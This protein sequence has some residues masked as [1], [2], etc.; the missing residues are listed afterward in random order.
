MKY[1]Q[2][3][4][5]GLLLISCGKDKPNEFS[6][7]VKVNGNYKEYLYLNYDNKKDSSL[8][9]NGR[10]FFNGSVSYPISA[11][12]GTNYISAN[13]KIFYL[14]NE[15][16]ETEITI[17][18]KKIKEY[19][20]DWITI[21]KISGT[22]ASIIGKDFE[23]FKQNSKPDKNWQT[24]LFE[25]LKTI[26]SQNPKH[27]YAG[28]LLSDISNDTILSKEQIG[29]LYNKLDIQFQ[30]PYSVK[31]IKSKAFPEYKIKVNDSIYDFALPN[32]EKILISTKD[33]RGQ[34]LFIDFWASWCKPC[35]AQF[36]ELTIINNDFKE[37]GVKILGVSIDEKENDWLKTM[38][39]EK[40]KWKNVIDIEGFS[41]KLADKYGIFA[42]PYNVL[43]DEKG[44][45]IAND[46]SLGKL[47][48]VLDSITSVRKTI[49]NK[50]YTKR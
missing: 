2:I 40:P 45:V 1:I 50:P 26:I 12:Y 11:S 8:V 46:V 19:N 47:R 32:K 22:E 3:L 13:E 18:K 14:E 23:D 15:K 28:D 31:S 29:Q 49:A 16:I 25:K 30:D 9:T 5:L 4:I 33:F 44:K 48:K 6:L 41:G 7:D 10:A 38:D 20:I 36:P 24:E 35:R 21:N 27:R 39:A 17:S 43:V 37:K 42:I 34:I